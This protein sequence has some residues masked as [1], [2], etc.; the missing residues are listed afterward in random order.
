MGCGSSKHARVAPAAPAAR[1]APAAPSAPAAA[2][3]DDVQDKATSGSNQACLDAQESDRDA[4]EQPHNAAIIKFLEDKLDATSL[5][6][7]LAPSPEVVTALLC[8]GECDLI[9]FPSMDPIVEEARVLAQEAHADVGGV[10]GEKAAVPAIPSCEID[11]APVRAC[12]S[13]IALSHLVN[14]VLPVIELMMEERSLH[15]M[16]VAEFVEWHIRP[17]LTEGCRYGAC[18]C[19]VTCSMW[20]T[21]KQHMKNTALDALLL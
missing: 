15:D 7:H 1:A 12:D 17:Q 3:K 9:N 21:T 18:Q 19:C 11:S 2:A 10:D 4:P 13:G 14:E 16:T 20:L 8:E 5:L 6:E